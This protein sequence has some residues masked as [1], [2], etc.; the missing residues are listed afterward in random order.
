MRILGYG[1]EEWG[2]DVPPGWAILWMNHA[3]SAGERRSSGH[4]KP[5]CIIVKRAAWKGFR[6]CTSEQNGTRRRQVGRKAD[7]VCI[8]G[9]A[10]SGEAAGIPPGLGG[11]GMF[12]VLN[13]P[14]FFS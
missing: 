11:F 5:C 6:D 13:A 3:A 2:G 7:A 9:K 14:A 8:R 12:L 1:W 10:A 4:R